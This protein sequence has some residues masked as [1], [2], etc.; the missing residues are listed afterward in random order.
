LKTSDYFTSFLSVIAIA[1][2]ATTFWVQWSDKK[3]ELKESLAVYPKYLFSAKSEP[4][5][6]QI[7]NMGRSTVYLN[8]VK[9]VSGY[10]GSIQYKKA[11]SS[12]AL[13]GVELKPGQPISASM[14][15]T[16]KVEMNITLFGTTKPIHL[17]VTTTKGNEF[18]SDEVTRNID[19][20]ITDEDIDL[21]FKKNL[22]KVSN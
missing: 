11:I 16:D 19:I 2:S 12:K 6:F 18:V 17:V 21:L 1:L 7:V 10:G 22:T 14:P 3:E 20:E 9:L 15:Y 5:V 13:E 8:E 4:E